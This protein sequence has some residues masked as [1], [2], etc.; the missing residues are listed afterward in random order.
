MLNKKLPLMSSKI[1]NDKMHGTTHVEPKFAAN[2]IKNDVM[3]HRKEAT[4][5][6]PKFAA[7]VI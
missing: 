3:I 7:Y 1:H 2:V 5:V 4:P 6:E